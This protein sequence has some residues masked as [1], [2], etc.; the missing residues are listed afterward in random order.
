MSRWGNNNQQNPYSGGVPGWGDS[1]MPPRGTP[2]SG[3]PGFWGPRGPSPHNRF[4]RGPPQGHSP[5][6]HQSP[7]GQ[8]SPM[9]PSSPF[10]QQ[11]P[12]HQ[13]R[14][15][16]VGGGG[17]GGGGGGNSPRYQ[18]GG[19]NS[20]GGSYSSP[21]HS[22]PRNFFRGQGRQSSGNGQ[23]ADISKYYKHSMVVDPWKHLMTS[24]S[25]TPA[26]KT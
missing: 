9:Y 20:G 2:H 8:F 23:P 11:A 21:R 13:H 24:S 25:G 6:P 18:F 17:G 7:R 26:S 3:N 19:R 5:S 15:G 1:P 16:H 12:G 10:M 14:M 22:S 4:D